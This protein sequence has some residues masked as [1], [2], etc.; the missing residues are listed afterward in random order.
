MYFIYGLLS[1]LLIISPFIKDPITIS[2]LK[3]NGISIWTADFQNLVVQAL[4]AS[5][6]AMFVL[7]FLFPSFGV[8]YFRRRLAMM[9][10]VYQTWFSITTVVDASHKL[11]DFHHNVLHDVAHHS[12][13]LFLKIQ[14]NTANS[15]KVE[16]WFQRVWALLISGKFFDKEVRKRPLQYHE[17]ATAHLDALSCA[18]RI[19]VSLWELSPE[20]GPQGKHF[21]LPD[22]HYQPHS[23]L[24]TD[25]ISGIAELSKAYYGAPYC[26]SR[27]RFPLP[28]R[29]PN[30][31]AQG[32]PSDL[33]T[34]APESFTLEGLALEGS[35][36]RLGDAL[37]DW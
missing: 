5:V 19:W 30:I 3:A 17:T 31:L 10:D 25:F 7:A 37:Y 16:L 27:Y 22:S 1:H 9:L 8:D 6:V 35:M 11:K 36:T 21:G 14:R 12:D 24:N 34:F 2:E 32:R 13:L 23:K 4:L 29:P 26:N 18:R 33:S 15:I 20:I 28:A